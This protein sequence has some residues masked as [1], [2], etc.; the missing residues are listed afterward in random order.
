VDHV[1]V[2]GTGPAVGWGVLTHDLALP[3]TL[4]R[5]LA[6]RTGRGA[7][8]DVA[9]FQKI[10]MAGTIRQ[11]EFL[12][13]GS[14]DA[15]VLTDGFAAA[16]S[17]TSP[18]KWRAHMDALITKIRSFRPD[19]DI[20]ALGIHPVTA[21]SGFGGT[22]GRIASR[23]ARLLNSITAAVCA[24]HRQTEFVP[25]HALSVEE[26]R[27]FG[28]AATYRLLAGTIADAVG[29]LMERRPAHAQDLGSHNVRHLDTAREAERQRAVDGLNVIDTDPEEIFD[30]IV[31]LAQRMFH[32]HAAAI[33]IIDHDREWHKARV[34]P[35]PIQVPRSSSFCAS[36]MF[37]SSAVVIPDAIDDDRFADNPQVAENGGI[38]FYAGY[39][40]KSS[41]GEA[42]GAL[43]VFDPL[44]RSSSDVDRVALRELAMLAQRELWRRG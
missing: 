37:Q 7:E 27:R 29:R 11:V 26:S 15:V 31:G 4:A 19:V 13:A 30:T 14:Y 39:P 25:F 3:G 41:S 10:S 23:H 24:G 22:L 21:A 32:T 33:S 5:A 6:R 16:V 38:R 44:P 18:E 42:V 28:G 9:A 35:V 17:L 1:L 36:T 43:C 12:P 20:V 8:V 34:G 2:F 40:L